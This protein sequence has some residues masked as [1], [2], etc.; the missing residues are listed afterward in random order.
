MATTSK[1]VLV[2]GAAGFVGAN[3]CDYVLANHPGYALVGI[4]NLC[5]GFRENVDERVTFVEM[6][7]TDH[8]ALAALFEAHRFDYVAH[9][10]AFAAEG[11]SNFVRRYTYMNNVV[12]STNLINCAINHDVRRFTFFSSI[13][14][15][16]ALVPPFKEDMTRVPIDIYGLAKHVTCEDLRIAADHH[17]LEY[18]I[19][20]PYNI[21][22]P[23]QALNSRY[24]N[25]MGIFMNNLL[26]G[27]P[28]TIYGDGSQ[29]RA[30]TYIDDILPSVWRALTDPGAAN[31]M[32]NLGA[33]KSF[34]VEELAD[35]FLRVTGRGEKVYLEARHEVQAAYCD[36]AKAKAE[37]G[38]EEKTELD[39]GI[40][41]MWAWAQ[42]QPRRPVETFDDIEVRKGLYGFWK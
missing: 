40:A 42:T 33:S 24:R 19:I 2:T 14:S 11:L 35:A 12:G 37:L 41:K 36:V 23:K 26:E 29:S 4:D 25:V 38:F 28:L 39:E 15:Y 8:V 7:I 1:T 13:A 21:Y 27:R 20:V 6:D 17:G 18:S 30:F 31:Q 22:G 5:T 16:G 3:F 10:A 9:F 32:F 34:T